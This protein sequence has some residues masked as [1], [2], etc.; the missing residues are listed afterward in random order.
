MNKYLDFESDI[1]ILD[2]KINELHKNDNNFIIKKN[3]LIEK[4]KI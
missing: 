1:E 2:N 3:K 4:K